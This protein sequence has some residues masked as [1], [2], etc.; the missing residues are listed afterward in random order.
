M[1]IR[2]DEDGFKQSAIFKETFSVHVEINFVG[3][4]SV[5]SSFYKPINS[6]NFS[7]RDTVNSVGLI[8]RRLPFTRSSSN[9]HTFR[10]AMALDERRAKFKAKLWKHSTKEE[11]K[12]AQQYDPSPNLLTNVKEVSAFTLSLLIHV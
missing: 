5:A 6:S 7:D 4:W 8:P 12:S 11:I 1:F 9:V 2:D 3:V 10:H